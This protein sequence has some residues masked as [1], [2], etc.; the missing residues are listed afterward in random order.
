[1]RVERK[2]DSEVERAEPTL[3]AFCLACMAREMRQC[4]GETIMAI[5]H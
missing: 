5:D 3:E 4:V 2:E 1:M